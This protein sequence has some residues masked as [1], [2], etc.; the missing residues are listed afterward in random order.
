MR[1]TLHRAGDPKPVAITI[2]IEAT[3]VVGRSDDGAL[4]AIPLSDVDIAAGGFDGNHVFCRTPDGT[5][6]IATDDATMVPAL[7]AV[8]D[9]R[10]RGL[11]VK[12]GL[13]RRSHSRW[14]T[15]GISSLLIIGV[16]AVLGIGGA[17]FVAPRVLAGSV[18]SL[19]ISIDRQLG[20][21]ASGELDSQGP[22]VDDP[23]VVGFIEQ[24][25]T[26]L[27]PFAATPGFE[28]RIRVA[29]SEQIN[30]FAL[31]GGQ[32]VA[33]T[34]LIDAAARPE[35]VAGVLA[36][37]IAHVTLRHG[38][39]NI[40]HQASLVVAASILLG[41]VSGWV[42]LAAQA[43]MLAQSNDYSREQEAEADAEGARM[44][45]AAGLDPAGLAE[46]FRR[47]QDEAGS[48]LSGAMTWLSTHPDHASRIAHIEELARTLPAAPRRPLEVSWPAVQDAARLAADQP[49]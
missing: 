34:G 11:L 24:I 3:E 29:R 18:Q 43:A 9:E 27:E 6:T 13:H 12:V 19:P 35:Q 40:A 23:I 33:F 28:Y 36:H 1:G 8:A 30:A 15:L 31:P 17:L 41:D 37:E 45:M 2:S 48:E 14:R 46:F 32:I 5:M 26:R 10:L 44:L 47:L 38:M 20:D 22:I 42:E 25:V 16:L 4:V 49:P 39:R 21:A 7:E